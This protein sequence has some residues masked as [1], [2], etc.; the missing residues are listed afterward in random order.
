VCFIHVI[1]EYVKRDVNNSEIR[2]VYVTKQLVL[3]T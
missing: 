2:F 1:Y 3:A